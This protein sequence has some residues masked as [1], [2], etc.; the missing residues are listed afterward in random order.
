MPSSSWHCKAMLAACADAGID[1]REIDGFASYSNDR[2][3]AT[4]AWPPRWACREL[5]SSTMQWGGGGG[6]CAAAVGNAAAAI[7]AGL[8]DCVVVFRAL[9]QGQHGRFGQA[10]P[11]ATASGEMAYMAPYGVLSRRRRS[12]AMKV[13]A[14]HARPRRAAGGAA[15][16]CTG[17]RT[18]TRRP[19]RAR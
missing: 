7:A 10:R 2:C 18:T 5:R 4:S 15:R 1:P 14:L 19:T 13:H 16:G 8:A 3:E 11:A 9:A 12:Y 6:G 17:Q